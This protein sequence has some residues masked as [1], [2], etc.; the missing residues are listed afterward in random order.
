MNIAIKEK[1]KRTQD[2]MWF[3]N[4]P[5]SIEAMLFYFIISK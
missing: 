5:T 2:L 1:L 3:G 4:V